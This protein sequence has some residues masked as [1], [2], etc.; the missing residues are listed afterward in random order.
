MALGYYQVG[1]LFTTDCSKA[2]NNTNNTLLYLYLLRETVR[3][4]VSKR[5]KDERENCA[6]ELMMD[7]TT[8]TPMI[9]HHDN[10]EQQ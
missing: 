10:N 1:V 2:A 9:Q 7:R 8:T 3:Y 4:C 5:E 6:C